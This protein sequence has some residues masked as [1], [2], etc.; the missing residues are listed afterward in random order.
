MKLRITRIIGK[1]RNQIFSANLRFL[2]GN[3]INGDYF[4]FGCHRCRTF[5]MA[6]TE[7]RRHNLREMKFLAFD[8]KAYQNITEF[9][10]V[11]G[12]LETGRSINLA[13]RIFRNR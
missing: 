10:H 6:L 11:S 5:R 4:E 9:R 3:R 13:G 2:S 12:Y 8:M 1:H 7:A